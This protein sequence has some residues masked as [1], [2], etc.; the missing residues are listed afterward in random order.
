[1]ISRYKM[2]E[3]E[4]IFDDSITDSL[5]VRRRDLLSTTVK[6]Y[7]W[8]CMILGILL[9]L[10]TITMV[11]EEVL[12]NNRNNG[13]YDMMVYVSV[14]TFVTV[15]PGFLLFLMSFLLWR[16]VKWAIKF[17]WIVAGIWCILVAFN[18]GI[19]APEG[20]LLLIPVAVMMPY[21]ISLNNIQKRWEE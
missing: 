6:V 1:M 4:S 13:S 5:S 19:E 15:T 7:M 16:E 21:W 10:T 18:I 9:M 12:K 11:V 14:F 20:L 3:Q 17:N 8:I 2:K